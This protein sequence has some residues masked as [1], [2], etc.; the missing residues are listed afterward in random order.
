MSEAEAGGATK[1]V[2][3]VDLEVAGP[4]SVALSPLNVLFADA[5]TIVGITVWPV[6]KTALDHAFTR[7]GS[8][9]S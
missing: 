7:C 9:V 4:A 5:L 1:V 8:K 3:H 6:S 2:V